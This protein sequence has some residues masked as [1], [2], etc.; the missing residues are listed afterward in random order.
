MELKW[1]LDQQSAFLSNAFSQGYCEST[2]QMISQLLKRHVVWLIFECDRSAY[3]PETLCNPGV[4]D[5]VGTDDSFLSVSSSK[6]SFGF[7]AI[8]CIYPGGWKFECDH[9]HII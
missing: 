1:V 8:R 2:N 4:D 6:P 5:P 9:R 3:D 7:R